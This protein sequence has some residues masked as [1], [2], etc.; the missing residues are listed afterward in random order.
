MGT[1][2]ALGLLLLAILVNPSESSEDYTT[3]KSVEDFEDNVVCSLFDVWTE[4]NSYL[5]F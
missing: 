5:A 4:R 1:R 2:L 3:L